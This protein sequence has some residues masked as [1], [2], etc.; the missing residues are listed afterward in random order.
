MTDRKNVLVIGYGEMGHAMERLLS[1]SHHLQF[2][3]IRPLEDHETVE[4][5]TAVADADFIL[6]CVPVTPLGEL[7]ARVCPHLSPDSISLSVAKGLDE[8]GRPAPAILANVYAGTHH[9]GVLY[10]P[11][12]AEEIIR[13]RTAFA[14]VGCSSPDIFTRIGA[15]YAGTSLALEYSSDTT[16]I[17][18]SSLLKN[19]YAMLIGV[20]DELS[21]GDNV[22]GYLVV[23]ALREMANIVELMGGQPESVQQLAG[24]G[25]LITTATSDSSHHHELGRQLARG[26]VD[27]VSGEGTHT[28][29][30][31]EAFHLFDS[32]AFPLFTLMQNIVGHP[33]GAQARIEAY[34]GSL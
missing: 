12:I 20:T 15:L 32:R 6:Y 9:Y 17:A 8:Q 21:M 16:G 2:W 34:L 22:R 33:Q 14:Q 24:L 5:E 27:G 29:A 18:W 31:V 13:G 30:M 11:M 25:D 3:D 4:L 10:G 26:A 28:L 19:V 7:A 23:A 1:A